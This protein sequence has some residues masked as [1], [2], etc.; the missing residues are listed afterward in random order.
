[1]WQR[2]SVTRVVVLGLVIMFVALILLCFL[3]SLGDSHLPPYDPPFPGEHLG[4]GILL[5][6]AWPLVLVA[7]LIGH[8]PPF[9]L[10]FPLMFMGGIFWASVIEACIVFRHARGA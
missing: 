6:A 1:M 5:V 10:W 4:W 2:A 7:G 8:D 3:A 9:I